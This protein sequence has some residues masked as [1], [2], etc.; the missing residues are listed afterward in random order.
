VLD[1]YRMSDPFHLGINM[2]INA[3][4]AMIL[5]SAL[6]FRMRVYLSG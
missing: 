3:L 5:F 2:N 6:M 1:T 4:K